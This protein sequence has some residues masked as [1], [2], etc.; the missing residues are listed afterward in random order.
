MRNVLLGLVMLVALVQGVQAQP[1]SAQVS[2]GFFYSALSPYGEWVRVDAGHHAWRPFHV[3]PGWR[4]YLD[5]R[6]VWTSYGWY[7]MSYEQYGWAV[8]HYGRWYY[9]DFYGWVWVPGYDWGPA[10]VEW[11]YND[12]YIGWAPLPPYATFSVSIGIRFTRVWAAPVHYWTF[13]GCGNFLSQRIVDHSVPVERTRRFFGNTRGSLRYD[14]DNGRV[15]NRGIETGFVERRTGSRVDRVDVAET[16]DRGSERIIRDGGRER[17]EIY[18]PH[19]EDVERDR[20]QMRQDGSRRSLE[21]GRRGTQGPELRRPSEDTPRK[22][23]DGYRMPDRRSGS[24]PRM[25]RERS[26]DR[27]RPSGSRRDG[28]RR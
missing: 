27:N 3:A 13:V 10:W 23:R 17:L 22:N 6:W 28:G 25:Q 12:D 2:F 20:G 26:G 7:W 5:G 16:Q 8:Y 1:G 19:R 4:P 14:Y 9:D 15:V 24:E 21:Q 18:R 11:R